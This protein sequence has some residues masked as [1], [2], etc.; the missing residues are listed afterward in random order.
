MRR[1]GRV[2]SVAL[3]LIVALAVAGCTESTPSVERATPTTVASIGFE[4]SVAET[5]PADRESVLTLGIPGPIAVDPASASVASATDLATIDLLYDTL[6]VLGDDG[7]VGPGLA[8]ATVDEEGMRW[9]FTVRDDATFADGSPVE[10]ADVAYSLQRVLAAPSASLAA[11]QLDVVRS[12]GQV[13]GR[14]VVLEV[15]EPTMLLP[16][17]LAAPSFGIVDRDVMAGYL[18]GAVV[19]PNGS[20]PYRAEAADDGL[21]LHRRRGG[22]PTAV[23]LREFGSP[24]A[25]VDAFLAGEVDWTVA[26][27]DRV[28]EVVAVAGDRAFVDFHGGLFLGLGAGSAPLDDLRLRR[29]IALAVDREALAERVYGPA[30]ASMTGVVPRGVV[31]AAATCTAPCGPAVDAAS[32]LVAE[33]FPSGQERPLRLLVDD[34]PVL[35]ELAGVLRTQLRA[36]G[37]ATEV[38]S[39]DPTSYEQLVLGGR[40]QL[41]V[42]GWL[43]VGRGPAEYVERPFRSGSPDDVV[44]FSSPA[45][46]ELLA[47]GRAQPAGPDRVATWRAAAT[48]VVAEAVVVPLVQYRTLGVLAPGIDGFVVRVDGSLDLSGVVRADADR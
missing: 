7:T 27:S 32:S 48:Q 29:A 34:T 19:A 25:A 3:A 12:I 11:R 21:V 33:V 43:G 4:P 15:G 44:G 36:V 6:T 16:E 8:D 26:G 14:Q 5:T 40:Q 10:A 28:A 23:R 18:D 42:F 45:V 35:V 2:R 41:F 9:T 13:G 47:A 17:I 22:G 20:G 39:V 46:D 24:D 1:V 37:L 31:G 38:S 30:A